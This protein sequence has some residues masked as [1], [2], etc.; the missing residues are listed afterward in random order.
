MLLI[1]PLMVLIT[2]VFYCA[3][4]TTV[5]SSVFGLQFFTFEVAQI[6]TGPA[7]KSKF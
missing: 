6:E 4:N 7:L 3:G 1:P 2:V 5:T